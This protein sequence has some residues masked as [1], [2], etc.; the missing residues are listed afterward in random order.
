M[1]WLLSDA[2]G[3]A[4]GTVASISVFLVPKVQKHRTHTHT[5]TGVGE[6]ISSLRWW[7]QGVRG[8]R[9]VVVGGFGWSDGEER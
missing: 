1:R 2:S 4:D 8:G 6:L 9:S 3:A 5:H 7:G